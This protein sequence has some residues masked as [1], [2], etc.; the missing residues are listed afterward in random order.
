MAVRLGTFSM[1]EVP[2]SWAYEVLPMVNLCGGQ[3]VYRHL[4]TGEHYNDDADADSFP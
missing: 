3:P 2:G 1:F 4:P